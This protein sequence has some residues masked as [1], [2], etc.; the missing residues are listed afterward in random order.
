MTSRASLR[1]SCAP[2]DFGAKRKNGFLVGGTLL[3]PHILA[4]ARLEQH[5]TEHRAN[6]LVRIARDVGALIEKRDHHAENLQVGIGPRADALVGFE[7]IVGAL[8][9]EIG[10]LNGH[11][12]S[13]SRPPWR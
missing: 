8:D 12:Q 13:A 9:G 4:D 3:Q 1:Y 6:L 7:Q 5:G 11:D 10:G 2:G